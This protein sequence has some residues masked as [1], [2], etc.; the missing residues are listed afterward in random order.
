GSQGF[1]CGLDMVIIEDLH[2]RYPCGIDHGRDDTAGILPLRGNGGDDL[3]T[4]NSGELFC[5][6]MDPGFF[7]LVHHVEDDNHRFLV[8]SDLEREVEVPLQAPGIEHRDDYLS[9]VRINKG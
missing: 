2:L 5:I 4:E 6:H 3:D 8:L 9:F 7:C 1:Y